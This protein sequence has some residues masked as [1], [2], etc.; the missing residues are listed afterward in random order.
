MMSLEAFVH[1]P[2]YMT[3]HGMMAQQQPS[4]SQQQFV[5]TGLKMLATVEEAALPPAG[6]M[7]ALCCLVKLWLEAGGVS[8]RPEH[9]G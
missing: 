7:F 4:S 9:R 2:L 6:G 5:L 3:V 1:L 8:Q